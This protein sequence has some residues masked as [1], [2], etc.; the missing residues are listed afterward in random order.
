MIPKRASGTPAVPS[1]N[2]L[3]LLRQLA[4]AGSTVGGFCTVA[5]LTYDVHRR[6]R[7]AER[8]VENKRTIQTSTPRYDATS[9]ARRLAR[10]ME[11]AEAGEYKGA[12]SLRED[13]RKF[14]QVQHDSQTD[15]VDP[16]AHVPDGISPGV[17]EDRGTLAQDQPSQVPLQSG[18][19]HPLGSAINMRVT[20][21]SFLHTYMNILDRTR[22]FR[23]YHADKDSQ[24]ST[25]ELGFLSSLSQQIQGL[26]DCGRPIDA[27][28]IFLE[29]HPASMNGLS[30]ERSELATRTFFINC[31]EGNVFIARSIF[32]RL[33]ALGIVSLEMWQVLLFALAKKGCIESTASLYEQYQFKF[34]IPPEMVDIVIRC[35]LESHR[36]TTAKWVLL[37]NLHVDRDCGL[38]G[39]YLTGIWK[40]TGSIELLHGQLR[41]IL[42]TLPQFGKE[43]SDKLFNPVIKA[44]VDFGRYKD[45]EA[46]ANDMTTVYDI[47]LQCRTVG[48]LVFAKALQCDW[49]GVMDGLQK[50]HE[51]KLTKRKRD[52]VNI[53]DRIF[54]EYWVSHSGLEIRDFL[55]RCINDFDI[56]PDRVLYQH[57]LEAFVEKGDA[58]MIAEFSNF[59]RERSWKIPFNEDQFLETLRA[60]RLALEDGPVGFWQML[61]AARVRHGQASTSKHILGYDQHS[62]PSPEVNKMPFTQSPLPWY[63]RSVQEATPS[64][65]ASQYIKLHKRMAHYMHVGKMGDALECFQSAKRARFH[66]KLIHVELAVIATLLEHGIT[67]ARELIGAEWPSIRH[68]ARAFPVFWSRILDMDDKAEKEQ[69][70][71]AVF[72]FYKLCSSTKKMFVKHHITVAI[73]RRLIISKKADIALD[74]MASIYMTRFRDAAKF[75]GVCLKMFVRAF[76]EL[77]SLAG[78]RWGVLSALAKDDMVT[79][80]L[81]V[82]VRRIL[83]AFHRKFS[84]SPSPSQTRQL[85]YLDH[86]ADLLEQKSAG[87]TSASELR[88]DPKERHHSQQQQSQIREESSLFQKEDIRSTLQ[89]WNEKSEL[90]AVLETIDADSTAERWKEANCLEQQKWFA[91]SAL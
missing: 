52:F 89:T 70:K 36:L 85:E 71:M 11:A 83:G 18:V 46:L 60:K 26:L 78:V 31:D 5:A 66:V 69:I 20:A 41:K 75:D 64:K 25:E 7:V 14:H 17:V 61:Q 9:A 32:E 29:T 74:L 43:P 3:R 72:R 39:A 6:V 59:A 65:P 15:P 58:D 45:A 82:E 48:L 19:P 54:L 38:C 80:D 12:E 91:A 51:T 30:L 81:V 79:W 87:N 84:V 68:S 16:G 4:L 35:L 57:I 44:Y 2:A 77:D 55:F 40:K 37:R 34:S 56:V 47:P 10:M 53:F 90:K 13:N 24:N 88:F 86:I 42:K 1:R 73:A 22:N 62:F 67:A 23:R 28:Q 49:H 76:S 33:E 50:M 21:A 63:E 27:A 8:I